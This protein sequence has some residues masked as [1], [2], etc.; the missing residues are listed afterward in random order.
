E[1]G[2]VAFIKHSTVGE[3]VDGSNKDDWAK[4]LTRDDFELLCTNGKRANTMD[5]KTCHL[6][7]VP[8]HA[9]VAR[10]EKANKIR[11]LLEGQEKL[12]G[13][14]GTEKERFMMFQSQTKDLLFKDLTKCLVKLRQGITYKEFLGDEYYAS[15][16][17]LNTCNP[18]DLLQVCT[19]LEDK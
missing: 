4:G 6:A 13:L 11:E 18:S 1:Q 3:N 14:H 8:T 12:F 2:D 16:A 17:S 5:Y 9:V 10:P 15:V 19:F 7:K